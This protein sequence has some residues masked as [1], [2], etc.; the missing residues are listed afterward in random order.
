MLKNEA[1]KQSIWWDDTSISFIFASQNT[2]QGFNGLHQR[3]NCQNQQ[4]LL[5]SWRNIKIKVGV[6][7]VV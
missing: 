1:A 4:K 5:V 7:R 3:S 6:D 2:V